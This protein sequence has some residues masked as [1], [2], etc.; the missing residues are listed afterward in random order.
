MSLF[1]VSFEDLC[2]LLAFTVCYL[3]MFVA[4]MVSESYF[5][6]L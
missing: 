1:V 6:A 5:Y 3:Y 2:Y 4:H